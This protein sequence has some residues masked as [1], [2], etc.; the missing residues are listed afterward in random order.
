MGDPV[1]VML[2][3]TVGALFIGFMFSTTLFGVSCSQCYFFLRRNIQ[4]GKKFRMV[5][6]A[7]CILLYCRA[8]RP[9]GFPGE[10]GVDTH[11]H[12]YTNVLGNWDR[13]ICVDYANMDSRSTFRTW[14]AA[15]MICV[16]M[17]YCG[18]CTYFVSTHITESHWANLTRDWVIL[19][20]IAL[21][22]FNDILAT[23]LLCFTLHHSKNGIRATDNL[24][25]IL[26]AYALNTGLLTC[27]VSI[28]TLFLI[29]FTPLE[30]YY[31]ALYV[32]F[33]RLYVNSLLAMLN[34]RRGKMRTRRRRS[35][36]LEDAFEMSSVPWGDVV[37][38]TPAAEES[39]LVGMTNPQVAPP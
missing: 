23:F 9:Y 11:I 33:V 1:A 38:S 6:F 13:A 31:A 24:I 25:T 26:M 3:Q 14:I 39:E 34:W 5:I 4:D 37:H 7:L 8:S 28:T 10:A 20:W 29:V 30:F 32:I 16:I 19:S 21:M 12:G 15:G 18:I 2:T 27:L 17:T 36:R 35:D 22:A